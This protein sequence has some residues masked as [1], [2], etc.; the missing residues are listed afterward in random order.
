MGERGGTQGRDPAQEK[1]YTIKRSKQQ[2]ELALAILASAGV[3]VSVLE[4]SDLS[5]KELNQD[6]RDDMATARRM[7]AKSIKRVDDYIADQK[8]G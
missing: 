6:Q 7:L 8:K 5:D 4:E 1:S 2:G 3:Q